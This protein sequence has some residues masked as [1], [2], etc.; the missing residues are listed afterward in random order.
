MLQT[1]DETTPTDSEP[2]EVVVEVVEAVKEEPA[3]DTS[4]IDNQ[5]APTADDQAEEEPKISSRVTRNSGRRIQKAQ[6]EKGW[7]VEPQ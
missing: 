3:G 4:E 7:L 6:K 2:V 1:P 5:A